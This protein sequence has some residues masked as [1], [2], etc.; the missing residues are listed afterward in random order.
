MGLDGVTGSEYY[1]DTGKWFYYDGTVQQIEPYQ[2][3][4]DWGVYN[5][6]N[7][8]WDFDLSS[9]TIT[10]STTQ[11]KIKLM[12]EFCRNVYKM[13]DKMM[14]KDVHKPVSEMERIVK[15][16]DELDKPVWIDG[17]KNENIKVDMDNLPEELF[18][19]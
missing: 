13:F 4:N 16:L 11:E 7:N 2:T 15:E 9:F 14:I 6:S 5:D 19:I 3:N 8:K 1:T 18:E 17:S 10:D 12:Q